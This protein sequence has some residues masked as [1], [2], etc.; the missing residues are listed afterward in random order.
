MVK[1]EIYRDPHNLGCISFVV[2]S[3]LGKEDP[4]KTEEINEALG[5]GEAAFD[6]EGRLVYLSDWT[7]PQSFAYKIELFRDASHLSGAGFLEEFF[8]VPELGLFRVSFLE[9][10]EFVSQEF[11]KDRRLNLPAEKVKLLQD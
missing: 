4:N 11:V 10:L 6:A 1:L 2:P 3:R 9:V 8:D 5:W 7:F